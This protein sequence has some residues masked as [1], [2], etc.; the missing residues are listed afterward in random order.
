MKSPTP[1]QFSFNPSLEGLRGFAA[2]NVVYC[3]VFGLNN[4]LD[5]SY[6]PGNTFPYW[7]TCR[8]SVLIFFI[9]SGYVIELTNKKSFSKEN[10]VSYLARRGI[11]ILPIYLICVSCGLLLRPAHNILEMLAAFLFLS[12]FDPYFSLSFP[13]IAGNAPIWSLNYEVLY[14]LL[15]LIIWSL[16][17]DLLK[18]FLFAFILSAVG[19][20]YHP[21][22][23]FISAYATGW[24][25]WLA[26]V[27][28]ARCK[29]N[30]LKQFNSLSL[31]LLCLAY[32]RIAPLKLLLNGLGLKNVTAGWVNLSD[33]A[34]LPIATLLLI[35]VTHRE[36]PHREWLHRACFAIPLVFVGMLAFR[37]RIFENQNWIV[38]STATTF[39]IFFATLKINFFDLKLFSN[40]GKISYGIY[41]IHMP[42]MFLI[43]DYFP[44]KGSPVSFSLRLIALMFLT[45]YASRFL[46]LNLQPKIK[47]FFQK[48][49]LF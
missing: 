37:G 41:L 4:V 12:N 20:F 5:P 22:P 48:T 7:Q 18:L 38:A 46:E 30:E 23:Q 44:L 15:F 40:I 31:L 9:I 27:Y 17:I 24:I 13:P 33:L 16:K 45:Y 1:T 26:G 10:T 11:R 47:N 49:A 6:Q 8:A 34:V 2:L 39:A 43:H 14:Y 28:L 32:E 35:S 25:F 19:W 29:Q 36:F 42:T 3:H 21:F